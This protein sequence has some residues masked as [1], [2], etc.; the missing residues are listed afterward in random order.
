VRRRARVDELKE[1]NAKIIAE[2]PWTLGLIESLGLVD[3]IVKQNLETKNRAALILLDSNFEIGLKEFIVNRT[4]LFPPQNYSDTKIAEMFK[5]R[6]K[7]INEVRAHIALS[8]PLLDK[9]SH[10][11]GLRNKLVHERATVGITDTQISDY[12]TTVEIVLTLL[13]KIKFPKDRR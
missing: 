7:V 5:A 11:Y 2:K 12:Q 9:I 8:Q 13:F 10:Y 6:Y 4:D 1:K 3:V